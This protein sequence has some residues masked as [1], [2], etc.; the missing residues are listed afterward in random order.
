MSW[1]RKMLARLFI[2]R[3][4]VGGWIAKVAAFYAG[5]RV[6]HHE[7]YE[8]DT[9]EPL[10]VFVGLWLCGIAPASLFDQI[11]KIGASLQSELEQQMEQA[12]SGAPKKP[13]PDKPKLE[14]EETNAGP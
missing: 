11:R 5:I 6:L 2:S 9:S 10:L 8:T 7:V 14:S 1:R 12:S 13:E 4:R 3:R